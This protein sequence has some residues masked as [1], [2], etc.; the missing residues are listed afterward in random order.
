M[1]TGW[2]AILCPANQK[3]DLK[4]ILTNILTQSSC[5]NSQA[6]FILGARKVV[7]TLV[8]RITVSCCPEWQ[9]IILSNYDQS[10]DTCIA[11][12]AW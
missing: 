12:P 10:I 1:A 3:P 8:L 6:S 4:M 9:I 5:K 11:W 2:L 7:K